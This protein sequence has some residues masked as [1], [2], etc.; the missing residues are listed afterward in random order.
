LCL[1]SAE[2]PEQDQ[3]SEFGKRISGE[4]EAITKSIDPRNSPRR[5]RFPLPLKLKDIYISSGVNWNKR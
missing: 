1:F 3:F 2:K 4:I 5:K